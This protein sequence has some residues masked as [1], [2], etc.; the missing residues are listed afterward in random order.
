MVVGCDL[1]NE[2]KGV[3]VMSFYDDDDDFEGNE[4]EGIKQ[5]R[6]AQ[7]AATKRIKELESELDSFRSTERTRSVSDV[8][9]ARGLNSKIADL[10]PSDLR[11]SDDINRWLDER[12]DVFAGVQSTPSQAQPDAHTPVV[13]PMNADRMQ[14]ILDQGEPVPGDESQLLAQIQAA[15]SP[16]ELNRLLFGSETGPSVY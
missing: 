1:T 3:T 5:L 13:P 4:S 16:A 14:S 10:I 12:A 9:A 2:R 15:S 6:S 8:L 7:K 11:G